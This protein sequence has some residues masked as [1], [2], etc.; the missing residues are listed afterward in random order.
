M[1]VCADDSGYQ[2]AQFYDSL[3]DAVASL[4]VGYEIYYQSSYPGLYIPFS[5]QVTKR[6]KNLL[7]KQ[8]KKKINLQ[9]ALLELSNILESIENENS[10]YEANCGNYTTDDF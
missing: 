8:Q 4:K 2:T 9:N 5:C 1:T 7:V 6:L 3:F 10:Q